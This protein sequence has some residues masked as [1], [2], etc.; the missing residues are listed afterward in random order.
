MT[1]PAC[2]IFIAGGTVTSTR[3]AYCLPSGARKMVPFLTG[4]GPPSGDSFLIFMT[5]AGNVMFSGRTSYDLVPPATSSL[6]SARNVCPPQNMSVG[7]GTSEYLSV[8][9][10]HRI[11]LNV[12]A[13]KFCRL[14]PDP[15]TIRTL[16]VLSSAA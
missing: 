1:W 10:S 16:P 2:R 8:A 6:P 4:R 15:A 3:V 14:L 12:P 11:V 13:S 9:G 5:P 7:V